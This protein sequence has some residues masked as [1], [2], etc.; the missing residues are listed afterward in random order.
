MNRKLQPQYLQR[1]FANY[2]M[3]IQLGQTDRECFPCAKLGAIVS[4]HQATE[5]FFYVTIPL[6]FMTKYILY[7]NDK[8]SIFERRGDA[9][10]RV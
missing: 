8:K 7:L 5:R 6:N 1:G 3:F 9:L 2:S 10:S 4:L